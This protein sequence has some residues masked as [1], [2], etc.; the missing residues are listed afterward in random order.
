MAR[1][2]TA[3]P[4]HDRDQRREV[5]RPPQ[6]LAGD[7]QDGEDDQPELRLG[8]P[9]HDGQPP[10]QGEAVR[11]QRHQG[12]EEEQAARRVDLAPGR[13]RQD[14][15]R[16]EQ[17]A[18]GGEETGPRSGGASDDRVQGE[19]DEQVERDREALDGGREL[20]T[21]KGQTDEPQERQ[22]GGVDGRVVLVEVARPEQ[23]HVLGPARGD[24]HVTKMARH[25][26][27]GQTEA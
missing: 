23:G 1:A 19:S 26:K 22:E 14:Q 8:E 27:R 4:G 3:P 16:V 9:R 18:A 13:P 17:V 12:E 24:C 10:G 5:A 6:P 21:V 2:A 20:V 15:R 11:R 7:H 25:R